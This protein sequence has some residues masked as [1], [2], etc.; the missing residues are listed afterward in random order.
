MHSELQHLE[1]LNKKLNEDLTRRTVQM[2]ELTAKGEMYDAVRLKAERLEE[3]YQQLQQK[4]L[5]NCIT[6]KSLLEERESQS[7]K[8]FNLEKSQD[9]LRMDKMYLT[10]EVERITEC[11]RNSEKDKERLE[12]KQVELKRAKEELVEKLVRV[13]EEHQHSYEEKLNAE[14]NRLQTRTASDLE[15]IRSNQRDAYEREIAGL[16]ES[17]DQVRAELEKLRTA[18]DGTQ[19][20]Y[21]ALQEEHR[22]LQSQLETERTDTR[23]ALKLKSFEYERLSLTYEESMSDFR[24][25]KID[26]EVQAKKQT[27]LKQEFYT[28]QGDSQ[29][30]ILE[31]E[32][33]EKNLNEKLSM[34]QQLEYE[35]DMAILNAGGVD[36]VQDKA[37]L[38]SGQIRGIHHM[39]E[40]LGSNVPTANKR[41]I[42]QSILLAQQLVEK[43]KQI[44]VMSKEVRDYKDRNAELDTELTSAKNSL[45][46]VA[47][48]HNYLIQSLQAKEAEL[49]EATKKTNALTRALAEREEE[50]KRAITLK[51]QMEAD[52]HRLLAGKSQ[53]D[54]LKDALMRG[55]QQYHGRDRDQLQPPH[56]L[57]QAFKENV[58]PQQSH[59]AYQ[60]G[61]A[62]DERPYASLN[63]PKQR[64]HQPPRAGANAASI[65]SQPA[66]EMQYDMLD[67][68]GRA[69]ARSVAGDASVDAQPKP[70]W[71][72]KLTR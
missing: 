48:P 23:N 19:E 55:Q 70:M 53:L 43:Q 59:A 12:V 15:S 10:K 29:K 27:V 40:S 63:D 21:H 25:L 3:E 45:N 67:S 26:H 72:R 31:L 56:R 5:L 42:K 50:L 30:R 22:R 47:Q 6:N 28:L 65:A 52:L 49:L 46:F 61:V 1:A 9:L 13:R 7:S 54:E 32:A 17:R 16:K 37:A 34:Y 33:S 11:Y 44:E 36:E 38:G 8:L 62:P 60:V 69:S 66:A 20:D 51:T 2:N 35:L 68:H 24:K 41:R 4:D 18:V 64:F 58:R 14:L 57:T 39:L 71:F